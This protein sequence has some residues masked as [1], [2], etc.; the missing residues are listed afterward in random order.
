MRLDILPE[1]KYNFIICDV[2]LLVLEKWSG[3]LNS[4]FIRFFRYEILGRAQ[5]QNDNCPCKNQL[6]TFSVFSST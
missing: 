5:L 2:V 4:F 3:I 1:I 6:E